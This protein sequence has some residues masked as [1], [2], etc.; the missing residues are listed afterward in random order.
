LHRLIDDNLF[1]RDTL[2][3]EAAPSVHQGAFLKAFQTAAV[4]TGQRDGLDEGIVANLTF[5][6]VSIYNPK[7]VT[8]ADH[9]NLGDLRRSKPPLH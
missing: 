1:N 5:S 9:P 8:F 2:F 4:A 3:T 7:E 6:I